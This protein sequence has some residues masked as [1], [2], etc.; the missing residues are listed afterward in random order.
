MYNLY[1][2]INT[3][4]RT[5][6]HTY[7]HTCIILCGKLNEAVMGYKSHVHHG[8]FLMGMACTI[9]GLMMYFLRLRPRKYISNPQMAQ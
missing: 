1:I 9:L 6:I 8:G 3:Y 4:I 2:Y 7:I 5:Y